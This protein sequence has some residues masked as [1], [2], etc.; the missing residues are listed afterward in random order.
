MCHP[1]WG[2]GGDVS[3]LNRENQKADPGKVPKRVNVGWGGQR[4]GQMISRQGTVDHR[5]MQGAE[6]AT[7]RPSESCL[8][9][10]TRAIRNI[11]GSFFGVCN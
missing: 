9:R 11:K 2:W 5:A 3:W 6:A 7:R 1:W 8:S 10:R 4:E